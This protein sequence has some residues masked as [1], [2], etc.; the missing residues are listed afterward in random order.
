MVR[1]A[2]RLETVEGLQSVF[3]LGMESCG[4]RIGRY[5]LLSLSSPFFRCHTKAIIENELFFF[6][7]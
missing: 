1:A 3:E 2:F 6:V 7:A 4:L 5:Q